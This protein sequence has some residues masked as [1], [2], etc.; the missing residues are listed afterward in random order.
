MSGDR[1]APGQAASRKDPNDSVDERRPL[2]RDRIRI[3]PLHPADLDVLFPAGPERALAVT[4]LVRQERGELYVAVAEVDGVPVARS[5][6][7]FTFYAAER[8]GFLFG[9]G[10]KQ[11]WRR[12]GIA[13]T[14]N[15][16][17][18]HVA[19]ERGFGRFRSVAAK[20]NVGA[21][22][23]HERRGDRLIGEGPVRWTEPD[24][25]AKE[26]DCWEFERELG[27]SCGDRDAPRPQSA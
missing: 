24:G 20:H 10:V 17:L 7:D 8:I 2:A 19:L 15:H 6:L 4:W 26:V 23:W 11:E 18:E 27:C 1:M 12:R 13:S 3:R 22:R 9:S 14:I 5:C 21:V 16:H 25:T